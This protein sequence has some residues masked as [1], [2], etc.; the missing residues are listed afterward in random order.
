MT[1]KA[2][3]KMKINIYFKIK[4]KVQN[5]NLFK[6]PTYNLEKM[7]IIRFKKINKDSIKK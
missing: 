3:I 2:I 5:L 6:I 4:M 1:Y 7:K